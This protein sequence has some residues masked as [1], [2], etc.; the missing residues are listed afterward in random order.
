MQRL[1]YYIENYEYGGLERFVKDVLLNIDMEDHEII[2]YCNSYNYR[3]L[4]ELKNLNLG[5]NIK[6]KPLNIICYLQIHHFLFGIKSNLPSKMMSFIR[7][8]FFIYNFIFLLFTLDKCNIFHVINGGYPG[9][10][11]CRAAVIAAKFKNTDKIIMSILSTATPRNIF[12]FFNELFIDYLVEKSVTCF[13]VN[14]FA[15]KEALHK[16]RNFCNQKIVNVYTGIKFSEK[17]IKNKNI[18]DD[19]IVI[20]TLGV[21]LPSKGHIYLLDAA[22]IMNERYP[23]KSFRYLI[24]G[25]GP[26][27]IP[28]EKSAKKL[29]IHDLFVFLDYNGT[30][31]SQKLS[32]IDIFVFPSL[33]E[34]FPYAILEAMESGLPIIASDIGG[35]PEQLLDHECGLLV[36]TSNSE[37]IASAITFL[38]NNPAQAIRLGKNAR[39]RVQKIFNIDAMLRGLKTIYL[40]GDLLCKQ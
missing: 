24:I 20:G 19:Q 27:R 31:V 23:N 39:L 2:L 16:N 3:F 13:H 7:Y 6:I 40:R 4:N 32:K 18:F 10:D 29:G 8:I 33:H 9:A 30:E 34:S 1:A 11:S 22:R 35:I 17:E 28:L 12:F 36:P 26:M 5:T 38:I 14:S 21:L 37:A 25:N 15:A